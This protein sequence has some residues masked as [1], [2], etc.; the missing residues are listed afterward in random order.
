M[1][2]QRETA[3]PRLAT[4]H[5]AQSGLGHAEADA[6]DGLVTGAVALTRRRRE[7]WTSRAER[8]NIPAWH[9]AL[10]LL[11]PGPPTGKHWWRRGVRGR[12]GSLL[13]GR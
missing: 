9:G 2:R 6:G 7:R 4:E 5:T 10:A 13:A 8:L 12:L 3:A 1:V 11:L